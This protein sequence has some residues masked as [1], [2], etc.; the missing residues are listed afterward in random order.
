MIVISV[1]ANQYELLPKEYP[2]YQPKSFSHSQNESYWRCPYWYYLNKI[3]RLPEPP[4][5]Y[6]VF[7]TLIHTIVEEDGIARIKHG[8][9][10]TYKSLLS[11]FKARFHNTRIPFRWN[12]IKERYYQFGLDMIENYATNRPRKIHSVE[13]KFKLKDII[14]VP[15]T[16]II[17]VIC[18]DENGYSIMDYKTGNPYSKEDMLKNNQLTLYSLAIE[19]TYGEWP[20]DSL[21][22]FLKTGDVLS[23]K[24]T[25]DQVDV[26]IES[27]KSA[28][29][30]INAGNFDKSCDNSWW[31]SNICG[32]GIKNI[33]PRKA[34]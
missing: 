3:V 29:Q 20:N 18:K 32:Y 15:I 26:M 10:L 24:K 11:K 27:Y 8:K 22:Y 5:H 31:C 34:K 13:L 4:N 23:E 7:G 1:T 21:Y 25:K 16:G 6:A 9:R 19:K 30:N 14:S 28:L 33:C 17:D 2:S 12:N